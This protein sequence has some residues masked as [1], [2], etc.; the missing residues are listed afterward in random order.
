MNIQAQ[1][2]AEEE[3]KNSLQKEAERM[4]RKIEQLKESLARKGTARIEYDRIIQET[5]SAYTKILESSQLLLN[6]VKREAICLD[7][8]LHGGERNERI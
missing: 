4:S 1:I 5:E 6:M 3:E 2:D 7:G 8:T